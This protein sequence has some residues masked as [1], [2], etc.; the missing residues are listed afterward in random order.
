[1]EGEVSIPKA[2]ERHVGRANQI[3]NYSRNAAT[4]DK[5]RKFDGFL[6]LEVGQK[7]FF[8]DRVTTLDE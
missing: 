1:M 8:L 6:A 2:S 4:K 7:P 5:S 3:N